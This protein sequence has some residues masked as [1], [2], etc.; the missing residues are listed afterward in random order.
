MWLLFKK[1]SNLQPW[2]QDSFNC[3]F[4]FFWVVWVIA[5]FEM[6]HKAWGSKMVCRAS[7]TV[8]HAFPSLW[9]PGFGEI[10]QWRA[11]PLFWNMQNVYWGIISRNMVL[12][13]IGLKVLSLKAEGKCSPVSSS[14]TNSRDAVISLHFLLFSSPLSFFLPFFLPFSTLQLS[15]SI[16]QCFEWLVTTLLFKNDPL[17]KVGLRSESLNTFGASNH[18]FEFL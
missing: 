16:L 7:N 11:Q 10:C 9:T 3:F 15:G 2:E 14:S 5:Y 1:H 12:C 8:R 6:R 4:F 18:R 13:F 17:L